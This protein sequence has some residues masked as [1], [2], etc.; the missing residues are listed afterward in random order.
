MSAQTT[1]LTCKC[2]L[3]ITLEHDGL[4]E[5]ECITCGHVMKIPKK[6]EKK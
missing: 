6:K 5:F 3:K 2:G 1:T 4:T